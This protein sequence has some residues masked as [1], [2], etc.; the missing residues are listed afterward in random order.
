MQQPR[1]GKLLISLSLLWL[2]ACSDQY[3]QVETQITASIIATDAT[4]KTS[5]RVNSKQIDAILSF[6]G[7]SYSEAKDSATTLREQSKT[8]LA[9]GKKIDFEALNKQWHRAHLNYRLA[10]L[11]QFTQ[12]RHP[13]FDAS[14]L[15]R[16]HVR[17]DA[18]PLLPGYLDK[19]AGY[20]FSGLIHT[21]LPITLEQ[22]EA[23]HQMGDVAYVSLGFH[24]FK[25]ML[26]GDP[27]IEDSP[28]ER[29]NDKTNIS[30]STVGQ[31]RQQYL[32]IVAQQLVDD[33]AF[34]AQEWLGSQG[35]FNQALR[36][37]SPEQLAQFSIALNDETQV[38][39][40]LTT[41]QDHFEQEAVN[42]LLLSLNTLKELVN[43]AA[44]PERIT[45]SNN[46][47]PG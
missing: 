6:I 4:K 30:D 40:W 17:I 41:E 43:P 12:I 20:P 46:V 45:P 38:E 14:I 39:A 29:I 22:L 25:F 47:S 9:S 42:Q 33:I 19:I 7:T 23:E 3:V 11:S 15:S 27:T 16:F 8:Y 1:V 32:S 21:D 18:S 2:C 26:N 37:F 10:Q 44:T 13:I 28:W 34:E 31:R 35:Y 36:A 5:N 24:A